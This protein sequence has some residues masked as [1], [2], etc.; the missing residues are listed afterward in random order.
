L[1][2]LVRT[3]TQGRQYSLPIRDSASTI[4]RTACFSSGFIPRRKPIPASITYNETLITYSE[5]RRFHL[6]IFALDPLALQ[7]GR[8]LFAVI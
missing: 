2:S 6:G 1:C 5:Y 3:I 7:S 4:S 8:N